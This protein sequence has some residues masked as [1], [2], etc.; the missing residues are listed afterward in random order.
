MLHLN[1]RPHLSLPSPQSLYCTA[2]ILRLTWPRL[3]S[4]LSL[5][6]LLLFASVVWSRAEIIYPSRR[7][8]WVGAGYR[9]S[10]PAPSNI[11]NVRTYGAKADGITDDYAAITVAISSSPAPGVILLPEGTYKIKSTIKLTDGKILRGAGVGKTHLAFDL[12]GVAAD[13]IQI[14]RYQR[15]TFTPVVSGLSKGSTSLVIGDGKLF[16]SGDTAEIQQEND[17]KVMYTKPEWNQPW[18]QDAVG[19]F[20]KVL[21]VNGNTAQP[22][23]IVPHSE[24]D[25]LNHSLA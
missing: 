5:A 19:Q 11:V 25:L 4:Y 22:P 17:P 1:Q 21:S 6:V 7:V 2:Y 15:G 10:I 14:I 24:L 12:G 3:C 9:G 18:A 20:F 8:D 16:K 13:C 23:I